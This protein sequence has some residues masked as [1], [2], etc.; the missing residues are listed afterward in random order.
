MYSG[1]TVG[2]SWFVV[3]CHIHGHFPFLSCIIANKMLIYI[4]ELMSVHM[5]NMV[6][7][8]GL[9]IFQ[10]FTSSWPI[11]YSGI[12]FLESYSLFVMISTQYKISYPI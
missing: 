8:K 10:N 12:Y 5:D 2:C 9:D 7:L 4:F 6:I 3:L 11:Y 1:N